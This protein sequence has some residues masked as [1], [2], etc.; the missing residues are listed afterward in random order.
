MICV[1]E[2][3]TVEVAAFE[4]KSTTEL[5]SKPVPVMVTVVP[6]A[7]WPV[8]GEMAV[9]VGPPA[10]LAGVAEIARDAMTVVSVP[11]MRAKAIR[12]ENR[13]F[14]GVMRLLPFRP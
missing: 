14:T 3:T 7:S 8:F 2:F 13:L 4:P 11:S 6:P 1:G 9:T 10:A 12:S 5:P